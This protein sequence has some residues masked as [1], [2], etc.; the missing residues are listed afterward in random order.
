M[1]MCPLIRI[2]S[3][4]ARTKGVRHNGAAIRAWRVERDFTEETFARVIGYSRSALA[5]IEAERR[6]VPLA[7][8]LRIARALTVDPAALLREPIDDAG[9]LADADGSDDDLTEVA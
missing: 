7:K 4:M 2:V 9:H 5:N 6:S 3:L 1:L 8:L